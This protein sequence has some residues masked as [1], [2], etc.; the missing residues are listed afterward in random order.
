MVGNVRGTRTILRRTY[1][2]S[3]LLSGM[4]VMVSTLPFIT[5]F[6]S[7]GNDDTAVV[8]YFLFVRFR[9]HALQTFVPV[10]KLLTVRHENGLVHEQMLG[11]FL[12][13]AGLGIQ[14]Y[15]TKVKI[16]RV[17]DASLLVQ[18]SERVQD[19][20]AGLVKMQTAN[21]IQASMLATIF[22]FFLVYVPTMMNTH[23]YIVPIFFMT[24]AIL[25]KKLAFTT[26]AD[27][28]TSGSKGTTTAD[29]SSIQMGQTSFASSWN[30]SKNEGVPESTAT[31]PSDGVTARD[32]DASTLSAPKQPPNVSPGVYGI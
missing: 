15:D 7:D 24:Y 2:V 28:S 13:I 31:Q 5:L 17:L 20:R 14:A 23:E 16:V 29:G 25:G 10:R 11:S 3:R 19:I 21:I 12:Q 9:G 8:V 6:A 18:P 32:F 30:A 1:G 4:G 22:A 27:R 26:V